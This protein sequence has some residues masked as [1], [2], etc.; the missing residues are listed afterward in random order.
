MKIVFMGTPQYSVPCLRELTR[1]EEVV[2][3]FSQPDKPKGR[4]NKLSPTP[5]KE[6]ALTHGI[7]VF[8][9]N[10]MRKGEGLNSTLEVLK[11]TQPELIVVTAF[12]QILPEEV[13]NFPKFGCI[14]LHASLLPKF[15][16]A[17]PIERCILA[18]ATETGVT[19]MQMDK[20]LDTGDILLT[21]N[22]II[23]ENETA[24]ELSER[25]SELS[26]SVMKKTLDDLKSGVLSPQKQDDKLSSYAAML[27]KDM[28]ALEYTKSAKTLHLTV[29]AVTGFCFFE[30]KR[31]K[32]YKTKLTKKVSDIP[33]RLFADDGKLYLCASDYC[34]EV[35]ELQLEGKKRQTAAEFLVG[36]SADT[37]VI[38]GR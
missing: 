11:T 31:L 24:A 22:I 35:I 2:A 16:G 15:R 1:T 38:S 37:V 12:G 25:L 30:G 26:A 8:Q 28:S 17:A 32:I 7:P 20:G 13:I 3:V 21:A 4:G 36:H 14:N 9:P 23:G 27:T 5:V 19:A 6:Y 34:L 33:G 10:T 29:R 18:G